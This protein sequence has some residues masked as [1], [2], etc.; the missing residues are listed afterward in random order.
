M[1]R[2]GIESSRL[3]T[4]ASR[5]VGVLAIDVVVVHGLPLAIPFDTSGMAMALIE[6]VIS[7]QSSIV[8]TRPIDAKTIH[9][10]TIER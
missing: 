2:Q 5:P 4:V 3:S 8:A 1:R 7:E 6:I 9:S 10:I